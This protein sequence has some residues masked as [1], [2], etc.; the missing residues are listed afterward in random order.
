MLDDVLTNSPL[1]NGRAAVAEAPVGPI[2]WRLT[3]KVERVKLEGDYDGLWV[4]L[5]VNPPLRV[6]RQIQGDTLWSA[7]ATLIQAWN[8][9]DEHNQPVPPTVEGLEELP[10]AACQA[11][12]AAWMETQ[13]LPLAADSS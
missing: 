12:V 3:P 1:Q 4:D 5:V 7:L 13:K 2:A 11:I 6:V 10:A 9:V 8:F